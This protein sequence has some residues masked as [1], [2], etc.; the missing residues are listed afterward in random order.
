MDI[1]FLNVKTV[2]T[3]DPCTY[4]PHTAYTVYTKSGS[5]YVLASGWTLKDAI[6][7][8]SKIHNYRI[9]DIKVKRP[10][11]EQKSHKFKA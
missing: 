10:F 3:V 5:N 1:L 9:E 7:L 8:F 11:R 2:Q 6:R 4:L